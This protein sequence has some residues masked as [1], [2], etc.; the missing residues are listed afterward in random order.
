MNRRCADGQRSAEPETLSSGNW[1]T[2]SREIVYPP[3]ECSDLCERDTRLASGLLDER[4]ADFKR[5]AAG[6]DSGQRRLAVQ[7]FTRNDPG[8]LRVQ[9]RDHIRARREVRPPA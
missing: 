9:Q 8:D 1:G 6:I 2:W 5:S 3:F 4:P 7:E